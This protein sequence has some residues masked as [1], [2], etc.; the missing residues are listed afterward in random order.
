MTFGVCRESE[1]KADRCSRLN[2]L[3]R[4]ISHHNNSQLNFRNNRE[5]HT[6][7]LLLHPTK[8]VSSFVVSGI[9]G[10]L[11][12]ARVLLVTNSMDQIGNKSVLTAAIFILL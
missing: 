6:K 10:Q 1:Y 11:K 12:S 3:Q 9:I 2:Q 8:A 4:S 7:N 5:S